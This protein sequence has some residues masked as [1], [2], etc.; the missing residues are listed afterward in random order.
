MVLALELADVGIGAVLGAIISGTV[1]LTLDQRRRSEEKKA[2][3][4]AER[5]ESY[6]TFLRHAS[7]IRDDVMLIAG[8]VILLHDTKPGAKTIGRKEGRPEA[9]KVGELLRDRLGANLVRYQEEVIE[10]MSADLAVLW[11]A[12]AQRAGQ[13][14]L[15]T[16]VKM[17]T[18]LGNLDDLLAN[19]DA[20]ML[21][22][23]AAL[24]DEYDH[25]RARFVA[26]VRRDLGN[27]P[28][29]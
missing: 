14:V 22:D 3:F 27:E 21:G 17:F 7:L 26:E 6:N 25:A 16:L 24:D 19:L 4:L 1:L 13:R 29:A 8:F 23:L 18:Y 15:K 5:R 12:P 20:S 10:S 2:R 11:P 9:G 28:R